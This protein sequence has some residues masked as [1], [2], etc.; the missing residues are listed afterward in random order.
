MAC[1]V[2]RFLLSTNSSS[3]LTSPPPSS[4]H[5][6]MEPDYVII[7]A[8]LL[9]AL[10]CI[11]GLSA[12]VRFV[13]QHRARQGATGG[14][15]AALAAA[16][17]GFKKKVLQSLPNFSFDP[18]AATAT[19]S[20]ALC[21]ICLTDYT[22]G[23]EIKVLPQCGHRF[24]V[25]C[26]DTW[27]G[28]HSSCPSCRQILVASQ[29]RK[30]CDFP[31]VSGLPGMSDSHSVNFQVESSHHEH[32]DEGVPNNNVPP[33]NPDQVGSLVGNVPAGGD[34]GSMLQQLQNQLDMDIAQLHAQQEIIG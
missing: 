26:V 28:S 25:E 12:T 4:D 1:P 16:N 17:K 23:D 32:N 30:C 27:L 34:N 19:S 7:I 31:A 22:D 5:V 13:W 21:A 29:C 2:L 9:C 15:S 6:S 24:H 10:M 8:A 11:I 18:S 14:Q 3:P 20:A 33:V